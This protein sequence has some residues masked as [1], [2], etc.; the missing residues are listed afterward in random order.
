MR[1][2]EF[3]LRDLIEAYNLEQYLFWEQWRSLHDYA[4]QRSIELI[5]DVPMF[6]AADSCDVWANRTLFK[7]DSDGQPQRVAGVPPDYFSSTGQR[8]GNP[9]YRWTEHLAEDF[10]WW[11]RRVEHQL[12]FF[13]RLRLDHFRGFAAAWEIPRESPTA[14]RGGWVPAPGAELLAKLEQRLGS[15]PLIAEDLG[16]IT[17][18][19]VQLRRRFKLPGMAVLQFAFDNDA[20]NPYLPHNQERHSV[21]YTGTHDNNTTLGWFDELDARQRARVLE[22]LGYPDESMPW[23]LIRAGLASVAE[24]C[25]LPLQDLLGL[26]AAHRL[27]TPGTIAGNWQWRFQWDW[28]EAGL[29]GRIRRM[30]ELYGRLG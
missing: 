27:N 5:G 7:L 20:S 11:S 12:C 1:A 14:E 22:Y 9:V 4:R 8:W 29:A 26:Q 3:E 15:L 6:V 19:V 30:N 13:D 17:P 10:G 25:L 16:T 18:D 28:I 24:L 2:A 21:V 23:P